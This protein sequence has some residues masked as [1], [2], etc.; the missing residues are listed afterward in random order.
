MAVTRKEAPKGASNWRGF[1]R[2]L[3]QAKPPKLLLSI[4]LGLSIIST[5]VSLV[6]PLFTKNVVDSFS[7][8][9]LNWM[10][11]SGMAIAFVGS[12]IASGVSVYLLNYAGQSVVAG[13]RDRL[14]K[15][16]LVLPVGYYDNHQTGDTISRMTNDTA[17]IKGL[18]AEHTSGFVT[19][20][21]SIVGSVVVLLYMDWK[22]TLIMF[23]VFPLAFLILFPLGRQMFKISKGMQAETASFTSVLNR[24][25]SE[26]RLVK[27]ANAEP[28]EY[29]EG[30]SG[31]QKLFKFGLREGKIQALMAP[32]VTFVM[33]MLF[34]VLFGYGGMRVASGAISA[35]QLVA[36]MLYLFQIVMPITQITQFF[37][38]AQKAMGATDT[39]LKVLDYEEE[40]PHAGVSVANASQSIHFKQVTYGYKEGESVLKNVSFTMEAGKVTAIVGPSGSGKTTTFSLLE[41]FYSPQ[42]G[43]ITL[44]ADGIDQFSLISWR[45]QIGYVSQESP[46]IA[47]TI[48]DNICYGLQREVTLEELKLASQ[49]AYADTFIE[50]LPQK[51]A[52]EVGER[53]I[54]LS[55][56]QRQRIAIARALL[57]D[58][59]ILM[60]DEATSSLD[61]KSEV[62]VQQALQNLMQGRTTLVIAHRLSTVVD[63]DQIIFLDKGVVTGSG[64]HQE[65]LES[66][67]MY[68]EFATQQLQ[69]QEQLSADSGLVQAEALSSGEIPAHSASIANG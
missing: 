30:S 14:W 49:M 13:I 6:I 64:T 15:K 34:V 18:I 68:R 33:L 60:L 47:G 20:V 12:A 21:I 32:L 29:Q 54:K 26:I 51:Y 1:V 9:A 37:N 39:I 43:S 53:G 24:V 25:L 66:H 27:A 8:D 61:S 46:L 57:R 11:I 5:L 4:A 36:F 63:A 7:I 28:I 10:Q 35:G 45:S 48:R 65:L 69:L 23:S 42:R 17:V 16:L 19:G 38:Q 56:G 44:G 52:T 22:M 55:G 31:I 40:N 2:L 50:E 59:K 67:D 41:R 62:V 3:M 58:P